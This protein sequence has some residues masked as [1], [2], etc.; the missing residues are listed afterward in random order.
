MSAGLPLIALV[1]VARAYAV[2]CAPA[3]ACAQN[4]LRSRLRARRSSADHFSTSRG[5]LSTTPRSAGTP[6]LTPTA[7]RQCSDRRS[8]SVSLQMP[9]RRL[10]PQAA[11]RSGASGYYDSC[12]AFGLDQGAWGKSSM[13][14]D[15]P[16]DATS[17][18]GLE[19]NVISSL[20]AG[21]YRSGPIMEM[22]RRRWS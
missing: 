20:A 1:L 2:D 11:A 13:L 5:R 9:G 6:L 3:H 7:R 18:A 10:M 16:D 4:A 19:D 17:P 15:L 8:V 21:A 22:A 14:R 12:G